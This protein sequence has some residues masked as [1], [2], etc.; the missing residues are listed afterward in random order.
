MDTQTL[1][2]YKALEQ[3][4]SGSLQAAE[5]GAAC[6]Q[7]IELLNP[8]INAFIT[9]LKPDS[10]SN[11]SM[12]ALAG[13]PI[14][15]KDLYETA[16]VRTTCGSLFFKDYIPAND[17]VVAE[18]L[19]AAGAQICGKTNTH[20]I[21]LGVT[22][23]NPHFGAVHNPWNLAHMT[24]GSSSGSAAAV[25]VG[26]CLAAMGTDTGGSI[27]IP[28]SLCGVVGLKPTYGRISTRGIFP[29]SWNLDHAGPL[30]RSVRDAAILLQVL[31]GYD[32][33]DPYSVKMPV[34]DYLTG[35]NS[36]VKNLRLAVL[37]GTYA[38]E[39]DPEVL[40]AVRIGTLVF[41][42][43]GAEVEPVEMNFLLD[44]ARANSVMTPAD[45]AVFHQE[46]LKNFPLD[47]G[48]DI[49]ERLT[50][51]A[52]YSSTDYILARRTQTEM[53]R[54]MEI[55]FQKFDALILPATPISAPLIEG[56][57]ALSQAR[58]LTRFTAPFNLTGLPAI[59]LPCGF[60]EAGLPIGM[61]IVCRAWDEMKLLQIAQAFENATG[62]H[63]RH[64]DLSSLL[65]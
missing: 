31:A 3:M 7:R 33:L 37:T 24:G 21:A 29:L 56:S 25:A 39:A 13:I 5:L 30:T 65:N 51:G 44:A 47:F 60:S 9:I 14:A 23:I 34:D 42:S 59:S 49:R 58:S 36:G 55:F 19:K 46:R 11:P 61:Q 38:W 1:T 28:A 22:G 16:G 40:E 63:L 62:W 8:H 64:P 43:L 18:R 57:D 12:G 53:R 2:I 52:S 48:A 26:M 50:I 20:E 41:E 6:Q 10:Q 54:R 17:S 27:R 15:L 45:A 35:L 4:R 32:E